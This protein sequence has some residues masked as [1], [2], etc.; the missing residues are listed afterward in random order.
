M[1]AETMS[2][3]HDR[4]APSMD[5]IV[6]LFNEEQALPKFHTQL[7]QE[8]ASLSYEIRILYVDDG[9]SDGTPALLQKL[10]GED[11]RVAFIELSRN[12]GHQPALTAGLDHADADIVIMMDGDG[13]HPPQLI[14]EMIGQFNAGYDIVLTQRS[15]DAE[16]SLLKRKNSLLFY[17]FINLIGHTRIVPGAA[18]FRL[19]SRRVIDALRQ[20]PEYHRF[21]RGMVSWVGFGTVILPYT[22]PARLAGKP[23]YSPSKMMKLA[24][25]A[26]FSFSLLPLQ[27]GLFLGFLFF[28]LAGLEVVYVLHFWL[29]GKQELLVPGWSSLMFIILMTGGFLMTVVGLIGIYIGYIFQEVKR[30]PVYVI[31]TADI[32]SRIIRPSNPSLKP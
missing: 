29:R 14:P 8:I 24:M 4:T 16:L 27:I 10:A 7:T 28:V 32:K 6:P 1:E 9:S 15:N 23:K 2:N 26:I 19:L 12:F 13:Q 20:M 3:T 11:P 21:L 5:I 25:D 22:A 18:D 17:S 30:R 31:Q